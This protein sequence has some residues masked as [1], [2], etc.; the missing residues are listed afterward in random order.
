MNP[1]DCAARV[2]AYVETHPGCLIEDVRRAFHRTA[3]SRKRLNEAMRQ[4]RKR[5]LL[6][7][8]AREDGR[9]L[10]HIGREPQRTLC[11]TP[12][13]AIQRNRERTRE[14][15]AR[16]RERNRMARAAEPPK[17]VGRPPKVKEPA[18]FELS[19]A[20]HK[21]ASAKRRELGLVEQP[22]APFPAP[23]V[24]RIET[25]EEWL[26]RGNRPEILPAFSPAPYLSCPA[27][28]SYRGAGGIG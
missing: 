18:Q 5:G 12:E 2:R 23:R 6:R 16:R 14:A 27:R 15:E 4:M 22:V 21:A 7:A 24:T 10:L 9:L 1:G 8:E 13:E 26:A 25:T 20:R 11:L 28:L 19:P 3:Y 17:R